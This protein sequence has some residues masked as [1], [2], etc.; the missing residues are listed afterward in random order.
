ML[1]PY[2]LGFQEHERILDVQFALLGGHGRLAALERCA[3][4][5]VGAHG[6]A[7][8]LC[9]SFSNEVALV[10]ATLSHALL[11]ERHGDDEVGILGK[12]RVFQLPTDHAPHPQTHAL[13]VA[14]FQLIDEVAGM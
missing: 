6:Q 10:V 8:G 13:V 7:Y 5:D 1:A 3:H 9:Q 14:I 11:C 2:V 12:L 4:N